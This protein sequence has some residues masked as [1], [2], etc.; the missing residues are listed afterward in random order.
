MLHHADKFASYTM[1]EAKGVKKA[2]RVFYTQLAEAL[3]MDDLS[4]NLYANELLPGNHK[5]K[6]QS[7]STQK[8]KAQYFL[9]EV[10]KPGLSIGYV[11]Q[12]NKMIAIMESSDNPVMKYLAKRIKEYALGDIPSFRDDCG[13]FV[14]YK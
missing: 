6:M 7:L 4:A 13:T 14:L 11:E 2:F 5:A 12:F 8:E 9:D 3:P 10:I 1:V